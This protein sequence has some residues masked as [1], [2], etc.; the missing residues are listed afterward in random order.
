MFD[1]I[2]F[3]LRVRDTITRIEFIIILFNSVSRWK[4]IR[5]EW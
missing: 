1:C 5:N 4:Q 2:Y 3:H